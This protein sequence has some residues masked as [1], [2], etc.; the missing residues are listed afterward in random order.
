MLMAA[1]APYAA[2]DDQ[3]D[4]VKCLYFA[5]QYKDALAAL[6]SAASSNSIDADEYR[7]LCLLGLQREGDAERV[8]ERMVLKNPSPCPT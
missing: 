4:Q 2:A 6:G 8:V 3:L 7:V 1:P 5:A